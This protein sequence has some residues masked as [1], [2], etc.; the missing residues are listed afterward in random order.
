MTDKVW[1]P[2]RW[3]T[4]LFDQA[5]WDGQL[6]F[7]AGCKTVRVTTFPAAFGYKKICRPI[8]KT[9]KVSGSVAT[10]RRTLVL[11]TGTAI[12][13]VRSF[14]SSLSIVPWPPPPGVLRFGRTVYIPRRW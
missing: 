11:T 8:T 6:G 9:I 1:V 5:H 10:L 14:R 2:E 4:G 12:I 7:N 13:R 3:D